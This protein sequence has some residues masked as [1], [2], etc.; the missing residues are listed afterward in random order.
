MTSIKEHPTC[1]PTPCVRGKRPMHQSTL[2][3]GDQTKSIYSTTH[4]ESFSGRGRDGQALVFLPRDPCY[5][6][7]HDGKLDLSNI[8]VSRGQTQSRDVHAPK[9]IVPH[10]ILHKVGVQ[11]RTQNREGCVM[12]EVTNPAEATLYQTTYQTVHCATSDRYQTNE[13]SGQPVPWHRHNIITGEEKAAAGPGQ[14]RRESGESILWAAR[15]CEM[16]SDPFHLH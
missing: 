15:R 14:A 8:H 12:K 10:Y 16:H 2:T 7:Q 4:A 1:T 5:P 9:D 11:N 3:F 6:S 13:A